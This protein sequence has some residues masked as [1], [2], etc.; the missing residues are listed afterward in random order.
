MGEADLFRNSF[1][2]QA[3]SSLSGYQQLSL[4]ANSKYKS[5]AAVQAC[6]QIPHMNQDL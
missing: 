2:G 4:V 3:Q 5:A 6:Q 1:L